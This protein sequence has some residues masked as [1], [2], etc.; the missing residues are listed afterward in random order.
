MEDTGNTITAKS[1]FIHLCDNVER[2]GIVDLL[3]YLEQSDFS[4]LRQAR[5]FTVLIPEVF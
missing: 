2:S 5:D 3:T 4:Q 1:E